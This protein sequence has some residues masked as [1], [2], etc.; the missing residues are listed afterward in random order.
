MHTYAQ[1]SVDLQI[2]SRIKLLFLKDKN[3]KIAVIDFLNYY[4]KISWLKF[5]LKERR[6][7]NKLCGFVMTVTKRKQSY[8]SG[9]SQYNTMSQPE[10]KTGTN[11][12]KT[13]VIQV[14]VLLFI[15]LKSACICS[16]W[17]ERDARESFKKINVK[18]KK[19]CNFRQPLSWKPLPLYNL[20]EF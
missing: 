14:T 10:H 4:F 1:N 16:D 9:Q 5:D 7:L 20:K 15:G 12:G 3:R 2:D 11:R 17:I 8:I 13:R 18:P 19:T 6:N